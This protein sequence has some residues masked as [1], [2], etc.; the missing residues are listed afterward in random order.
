M[1]GGASSGV[2]GGPQL[3]RPPAC[4]APPSLGAP[5]CGA[6]GGAAGGLLAGGSASDV[7]G[8]PAG[9]L[10]GAAAGGQACGDHA[11]AEVATPSAQA[12]DA[13]ALRNSSPPAVA[14]PESPRG[15]TSAG[16]TWRQT[17]VLRLRY[18]HCHTNQ[19]LYYSHAGRLNRNATNLPIN[20]GH[21]PIKHDGSQIS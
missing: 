14:L 4:Q 17:T 15:R 13:R 8:G 9:G 7:T 2:V 1:T 21:F 11:C 18:F 16:W 20:H 19:L 6:A 5:A 3:A 12:K 10:A